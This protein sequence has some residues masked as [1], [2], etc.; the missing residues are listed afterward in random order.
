MNFSGICP[1]LQVFDMPTA[2]GFYVGILEF[3]VFEQ[4]PDWAWLK[5]GETELMLNTAYESHER[6]PAPDP[7]RHAAHADTILFF[8]CPDPDSLYTQLT[9]KGLQLDPPTTAPYGMRQL[10]VSD[11]DGYALC[12]QWP[13]SN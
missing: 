11:P 1:L 5:R 10:S 9:A 2:L 12:F 13:V 6:P 4:T 3:K 7:A 8:G